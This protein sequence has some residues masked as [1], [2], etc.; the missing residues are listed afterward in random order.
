MVN[1]RVFQLNEPLIVSK[2][3]IIHTYIQ[4]EVMVIFMYHGIMKMLTTPSS[5]VFM[6]IMKRTGMNPLMIM[7]VVVFLTCTTNYDLITR[8]SQRPLYLFINTLLD[9]VICC[10]LIVNWRCTLHIHTSDFRNTDSKL[11]SVVYL[12]LAIGQGCN[13]IIIEESVR[14]LAWQKG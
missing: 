5:P 11:S 1:W 2:W 9:L 8:R 10:I 13:N 6:I 14:K 12:H 4:R 3:H 7:I